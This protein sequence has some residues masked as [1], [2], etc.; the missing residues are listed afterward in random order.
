MKRKTPNVLHKHARHQPRG[1]VNR[2]ADQGPSTANREQVSPM[3]IK[4][5]AVI[6]YDENLLEHARTQWQFGDWDSLTKVNLDAL[7]D[8]P[9]R[10]KLAMLVGVAHA[11]K[12]NISLSRQLVRL[13]KDWGCSDLLISQILVAGVHN[14]LGRAAAAADLREHAVQH[15][16]KAIAIAPDSDVQ[17]FTQVNL[18]KQLNQMGLPAL[19]F[20]TNPGDVLK[21]STF[22]KKIAVEMSDHE[23][24][25]PSAVQEFSSSSYW[26]ERY[27]AGGTS[28]AGSYG[29]LADFKAEVLNK[30]VADESIQCLIE[31]GCGDGN[32]LSKISVDKYFGIDISS[33]AISHC[34]KIFKNDDSK[35]F[36]KN[37]EFLLT[38]LTAELTLSLDVIYHLVED[39]AFEAYMYMLFAASERYCIIYACDDDGRETDATHVRRRKFSEWIKI[40]IPEW[41]LVGIRY[42][43]YPY[44]KLK[45]SKTSSMSNFYFY[46][47]IN[48]EI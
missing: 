42:N 31:F 7:Q 11:Q 44:A 21:A 25:K 47:K 16:E 29:V 23:S 41:R 45:N 32:Q 5:G 20:T 27:R 13:A 2:Q 34:R 46:K 4:R 15:F 36:Y 18:T 38:P 37:T 10:A 6:P 48:D 26:E 35:I 22:T 9:H 12:N 33:A 1:G 40:N 8:H 39:Q 24:E 17:F 3:T 43:D 30:F 14:S 28:G 19:D